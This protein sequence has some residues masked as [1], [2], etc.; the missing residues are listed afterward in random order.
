M[1]T[2][3]IYAIPTHVAHEYSPFDKNMKKA[4]MNDNTIV[5]MEYSLFKSYLYPI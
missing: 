3:T 4:L 5:I 2:I 1:G